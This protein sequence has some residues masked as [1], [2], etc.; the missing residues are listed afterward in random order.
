MS[1]MDGTEPLCFLLLVTALLSQLAV[2]LASMA[3]C[4]FDCS[5][6]SQGACLLYPL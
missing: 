2:A 4:N 1:G 3:M 6:I 5:A